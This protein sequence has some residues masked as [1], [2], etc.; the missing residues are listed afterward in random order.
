MTQAEAREKAMR[1]GWIAGPDGRLPW[2]GVAIFDAAANAIEIIIA[3]AYLDAAVV[4]YWLE[5]AAT[6]A[7]R[8]RPA[9]LMHDGRTIGGVMP[10][11]VTTVSPKANGPCL[12]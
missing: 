2:F 7:D 6:R 4:D 1:A 11:A 5:A 8:T 12:H 10:A 3:T 9:R